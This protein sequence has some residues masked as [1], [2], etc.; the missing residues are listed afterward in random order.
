MSDDPID[1]AKSALKEITDGA[2]LISVDRDR[3]IDKLAKAESAIEEL[4]QSIQYLNDQLQTS[5]KEQLR[6]QEEIEAL[7][8]AVLEER[9][10]CAAIA[11]KHQEQSCCDSLCGS[12]IADEIEARG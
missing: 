12:T 2:R 8:K 3:V 10:I 9:A 11:N 4:L 6:L 7:K 5:T 1:E